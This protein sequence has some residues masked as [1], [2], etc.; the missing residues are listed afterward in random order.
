MGPV[1]NYNLSAKGRTI[2]AVDDFQ[3]IVKEYYNS[4]TYGM[5]ARIGIEYFMNKRYFI[6]LDFHFTTPLNNW[7]T[8]ADFSMRRN[9]IGS[10]LSVGYRF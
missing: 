9:I 4:L 5:N 3:T 7:N 10:N 2:T 6:G 8:T 1:L